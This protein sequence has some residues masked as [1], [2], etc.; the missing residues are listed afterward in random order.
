MLFCALSLGSI[1]SPSSSFVCSS[2]L[3]HLPQL[4]QF[5]LT[6]N[7]TVHHPQLISGDHKSYAKGSSVYPLPYHLSRPPSRYK[8]RLPLRAALR[9]FH[10]YTLAI[11]VVRL[12]HSGTSCCRR[13]SSSWTPPFS[14]CLF[15]LSL[16][17][18]LVLRTAVKSLERSRGKVAVILPPS[19]KE[20]QSSWQHG[21]LP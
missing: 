5:T 2:S 19:T 15:P 18:G 11:A 7:L 21:G 17:L 8:I 3:S 12:H 16:C 9:S 10:P 20:T 4:T 13:P 6:P 14:C 1:Y